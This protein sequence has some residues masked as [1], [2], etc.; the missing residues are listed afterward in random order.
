MLDL[1]QKVFPVHS[2]SYLAVSARHYT[3]V[4]ETQPGQIA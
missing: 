2:V 1:L 3:R 4:R